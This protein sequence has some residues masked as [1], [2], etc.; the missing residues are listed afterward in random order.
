MMGAGYL[1][2]GAACQMSV[3]ELLHTPRKQGIH[4]RSALIQQHDLG[5]AQQHTR[6]CQ[7]LLL[8]CRH[9]DLLTSMAR[10]LADSSAYLQPL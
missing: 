10:G 1:N 6:N 9:I 2:D 8:P 3:Q 5:L 4:V 7:Q